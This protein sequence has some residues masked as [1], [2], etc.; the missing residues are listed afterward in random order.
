LSGALS[1]GGQNDKLNVAACKPGQFIGAGELNEEEA[2]TRLIADLAG[3]TPDFTKRE[4]NP[5]N[6]ASGAANDQKPRDDGSGFNLL[7]A[8]DIEAKPIFWLWEEVLALGKVS[9]FAGDPGVAKSHVAVCIAAIVSSGGV[10]PASTQRATPGNVI[11]VSAEDNANDTIVPRLIAAGADLDK[12]FI[13]AD[14]RD[15]LFDLTKD[16]ARLRGKMEAIGGAS[17]VIIDPITAYL[18]KADANSNGEVRGILAELAR[19]AESYNT[20]I[21]GITHLNKDASKKPA[22]RITGSLG[23]SAAARTVFIVV[24]DRAQPKRR[25]MAPLKN[26]LANDTEGFAFAV[27]TVI[28]DKGIKTSRVVFEDKVHIA[29]ADE[30][31]IEKSEDGGEALKEAK[32]FLKGV[33]VDGPLEATSV[34]EKA[35]EAG[36]CETT[37]HRAKKSL[38]IKSDKDG[39]RWHWRLPAAC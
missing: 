34:H 9:M 5:R 27:E 28:L 30:V 15:R 23:F 36:I 25:I 6:R 39:D 20:C 1:E 3:V 4:P 10:W 22:Y 35:K 19:M 21:L 7:R 18:G 26:N 12:V 29:T 37:L 11:I 31:L 2:K 16:V 33:L 38:D 14:A 8:S 24:K 13:L 17:L 32:D